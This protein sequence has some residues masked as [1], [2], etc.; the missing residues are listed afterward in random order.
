MVFYAQ[1]TNTEELD[2][3]KTEIRSQIW[4]PDLENKG[5]NIAK[6][7]GIPEQGK[8][9]ALQNIAESQSGETKV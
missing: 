8:K 3:R 6:Y 5:L 9:D 1:S 4:D 7:R 2:T